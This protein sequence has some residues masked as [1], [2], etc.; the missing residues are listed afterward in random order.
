MVASCWGPL[1]YWD[2]GIKCPLSESAGSTEAW[3]AF[4]VLETRLLLSMTWTGWRDGLAG[5]S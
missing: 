1:C 2:D 3:R 5:T 4:E